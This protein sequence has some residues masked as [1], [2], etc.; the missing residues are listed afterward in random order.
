MG[1]PKGL[2]NLDVSQPVEERV[3]SFLNSIIEAEGYS[4]WDKKLLSSLTLTRASAGEVVLEFTVTDEMCNFMGNVHGGCSS[5]MLDNTTS[6]LACTI[7]NQHLLDS[8]TVSRTLSLTFVRP[9][10]VGTR[11][12]SVNRVVH[13]GKTLMNTEGT[14]ETLDGK[15]CVRCVH[16]KVVIS[17]PKL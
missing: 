13:A 3:T 6:L 12:R 9:I 5:T 4:G 14:L 10:P 15:V 7:D 17:R 11:V 2:A 16:D 8:Y 1:K